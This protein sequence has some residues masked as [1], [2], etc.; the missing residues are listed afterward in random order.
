[1]QLSSH[2]KEYFS[3]FVVGSHQLSMKSGYLIGLD[4]LWKSKE[5]TSVTKT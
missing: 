5:T 4:D 1:M 3:P 2:G